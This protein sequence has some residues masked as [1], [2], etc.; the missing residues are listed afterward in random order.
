MRLLNV[1]TLELKEFGEDK[2]PAYAIA[3]HR[4]DEH[5]AT[6][7][8]VRDA[9]NTATTGYRKVQEFAEYVKTHVP[10]IDWL[11][12]DTCCINRENPNELS[13]AINL[14]F[15]WYRKAD[16]CLAYLRD[17]EGAEGRGSF[18]RSQWFERGWTLQELLAPR[19]V[20]FLSR[21]WEVIG[22]KGAANS[23]FTGT[24]VGRSLEQVIAAITKVPQEVLQAYIP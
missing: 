4:W 6:F 9:Q 3:S 11:W 20:V 8:D 15:E 19:T 10:A 12:I 7:A 2:K 13:R 1:H 5:E 23:G 18:E 17:V 14:M 24:N 16:I 21:T 22:N